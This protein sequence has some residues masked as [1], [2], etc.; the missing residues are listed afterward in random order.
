MSSGSVQF[1]QIHCVPTLVSVRFVTDAGG[2]VSLS[3]GSA[4][5]INALTVRNN[6]TATAMFLQDF[7]LTKKSLLLVPKD[8]ETTSD[9]LIMAPPYEQNHIV[10]IIF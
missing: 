3:M 4:F 8:L 6:I 9:D 10:N 5:A 7:R 2:V 1:Q